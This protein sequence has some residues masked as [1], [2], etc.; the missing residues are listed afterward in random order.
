MLRQVIKIDDGK[1]NGCGLCVNAC[2]ESALAIVDG[3]AKLIRDDY[4]DGMGDC[5]PGCPMGAISFETREAAAYDREAVEENMR[6][7]RQLKN[8]PVQIK[9]API[10]A[11]YFE[12]AKLLIASDCSAFAYPDFH[13]DFIRGRVVLNGCPKLDGVDYSE[14]LAEIIKNNG[15]IDITVVRMQVPCCGGLTMMVQNAI[16][17]SGKD[18]PLQVVTISRDGKILG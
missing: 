13:K 4:C 6:L 14:K 9:L 1:C 7:S 2:H 8:W 15:I 10:Q 16:N 18:I 17:K 3:K 12:G 11:L 5:L